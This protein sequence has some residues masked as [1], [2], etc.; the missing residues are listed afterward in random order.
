[1][2]F[3]SPLY[4]LMKAKVCLSL[5]PHQLIMDLLCSSGFASL[6]V[7]M[8][9]WLAAVI[10]L[11]AAN[12]AARVVFVPPDHA[13]PVAAWLAE[14]VGLDT[15]VET[16]EPELAVFSDQ[17]YHYPPPALLIAA[18]AHIWRGAPSPADSYAFRDAGAPDYVVVGP[19]AQWVGLYADDDL[20]VDYAQVHREGAYAVWK[21]SSRADKI[22]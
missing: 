1:M 21:R 5:A 7:A 15:V 4:L 19:F 20:E 14:H 11:S 8:W 10:G 2:V 12:V 13:A 18:V 22:Q 16:W 6:V 3:K 17:R 9:L